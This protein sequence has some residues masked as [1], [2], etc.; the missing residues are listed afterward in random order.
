MDIE[1]NGKRVT[2]RDKIEAQT[3]WDNIVRRIDRLSGGFEKLEFE[4]IAA[5]GVTAVQ[6]WELEGDPSKVES[7]ASLD[8]VTEFMPIAREL[9]EWLSA[10]LNPPKN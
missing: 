9:S 7:W 6:S 2:F 3:G 4:D 5:L 1:I 8:L 10:K